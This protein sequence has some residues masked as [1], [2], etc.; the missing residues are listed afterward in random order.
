MIFGTPKAHIKDDAIC[1][2]VEKAKEAYQKDGYIIYD[3]D[4]SEDLLSAAA[5][6][7]Q[8][9]IGEYNRVQD[10]WR[11]NK[12]VKS[13]GSDASVLNLLKEIYGR[14]AFPFQTLNFCVGTEQATHADSL[15]FSCEPENFMCGVWVALE[16]I[17]MDNGPLHYFVGSHKRPNATMSDI[18]A[19]DNIDPFF[20]KATQPFEKKYGVIKRGKAVIWAANLLHG[21]DPIVD[22][23]RTRLSQVTHYYFDDCA[24]LTP[25]NKIAR[26]NEFIRN[27]YDFSTGRFIDS[28]KYDKRYKA[29]WRTRLNERVYN[30]LKRTPLF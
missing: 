7:T 4:F 16:D 24:Y 11:K 23:S 19:I 18:G 29:H 27:P 5:T 20:A 8:T 2:D 17:D 12:A 26:P 21:G 28:H 13:L 22:H 9:A 1:V 14:R 30:F 6:A 3:F 10:L 25:M 15:H